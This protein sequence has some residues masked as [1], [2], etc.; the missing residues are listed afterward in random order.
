MLTHI[1]LV[2]C[3]SITEQ[4]LCSSLQ[5]TYNYNGEVRGW[6]LQVNMLSRQVQ[7]PAEMESRNCICIT[8]ISSTRKAMCRRESCAETEQL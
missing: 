2:I 4:M 1:H 6:L 8:I 5:I 7:D 3:F